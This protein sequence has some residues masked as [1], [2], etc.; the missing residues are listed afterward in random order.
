[1]RSIGSQLFGLA[2]RW[3]LAFVVSRPLVGIVFLP[4]FIRHWFS[5]RAMVTDGKPRFIDS[6]PCL[7][8]WTPYT[9]FD[10][11]YFFQGAWLARRLGEQKPNLHVDVASSVLTV[12][13]VS[14]QIDTVFVDYRPAKAQLRG[15]MPVAGDIVD[16]PFAS[17]SLSSISCLHVIEHVGLG[18]Y[19]D[20]IDPE[21][22]IKAAHELQRVLKR[23]GL[24][25]LSVPVGEGRVQ[26]NAHRVFSPDRVPELFA[27]LRLIEF[28]YV[29]DSGLFHEDRALGDAANNTYACG[30]YIFCKQHHG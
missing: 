15:M 3:V 16:L 17:D 6:Y 2:K 11:H 21:G 10:P 24:L 28:S 13:T 29:D 22:S 23:N 7:T 19:G 4:K 18:R 12:G 14:A 25:Y 20:P 9:P 27:Q 8:D 26:F 1:M 5:Y 30:M